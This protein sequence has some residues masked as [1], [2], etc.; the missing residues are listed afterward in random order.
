[1]PDTPSPISR[2][3]HHRARALTKGAPV[4]LPIVASSTFHLPGDPD[5]SHFYGR[6]GNPTVEQVE[7]EIGI[8]EG[9]EAILFPSGMAA[10]ASVFY[11]HLR[12]GDT[13]LV[14][15]DGYYNVRALLEAQFVPMGVKVKTCPTTEFVSADMTGCKMV[16]I[17]TP[18][19][20]GLAVC[21]IAAVA[22]R[23]KAAG[24][25]LVADNTTATAIC[26]QPLD[27]GAD[28]VVMSDTKAMA[29]HSDVLAGHVA[30]RHSALMDPIRTWRRLAGAIVSPFDAYLLHRGIATLELRL[31]RANDNAMTA[32]EA[33]RT[34]PAVRAVNYPGLTNDPS[35]ETAKRQMRGF[36]PVVSFTLESREKAEKFIE[37]SELIV[38][39]TSFGGVHASAECR[40]RWGDA[41]PEGFVRL[42]CGIEPVSDFV[43]SLTRALDSV[44]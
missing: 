18:S 5:G 25:L 35:H 28:I 17:E 38:S 43:T 21:D 40:I 7:A 39:A 8:L 33:L 30:T 36:G 31:S 13:V 22:A 9:G 16:M 44:G 1:M 2:L 12:P 3:L 23:A 24:A 19:N 14:H 11:A 10:I 27:L 15:S 32:A 20:P 4:A 34:H 29:G 42:A 6:N 26:Q 41:V 37:N